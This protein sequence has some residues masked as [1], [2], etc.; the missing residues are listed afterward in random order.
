MAEGEDYGSS[1]QPQTADG[2]QYHI[3]LAPGEVAE[4]ILLVGDPDRARR[5]A[6]RFDD[7]EFERSSRE[8]V[9]LTGTHKGLRVTVM[10]TGMSTANTEI[11]VIELCQCFA[12]ERVPDRKSVV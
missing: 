3:G 2:R 1:E 8:Y 9:S 5:V 11:A 6:S 7:V 10:G 12:P 4:H